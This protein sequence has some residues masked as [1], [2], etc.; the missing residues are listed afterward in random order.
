VN[1][2]AIHDHWERQQKWQQGRTGTTQK[3][4]QLQ[5][6]QRHRALSHAPRP[7]NLQGTAGRQHVHH[8]PIS[9]TLQHLR[10]GVQVAD[11][12]GPDLFQHNSPLLNR[13][14][15]WPSYADQ[16]QGMDYQDAAQHWV[17]NGWQAGMPVL[18]DRVPDAYW[19]EHTKPAVL[20]RD[21]HV[22]S[23]PPGHWRERGQ[24]RHWPW[25]RHQ[26]QNGA[27]EADEGFVGNEPGPHLMHQQMRSGT[28]GARQDDGAGLLSGQQQRSARR[29]GGLQHMPLKV[30]HAQLPSGYGAAQYW[31][32]SYGPFHSGVIS[33]SAMPMPFSARTNVHRESPDSMGLQ[34]SPAMGFPR[35]ALSRGQVKLFLLPVGYSHSAQ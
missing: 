19:E 17:Q 10:A 2:T 24:A 32:A 26:M 27:S 13:Q 14:A 28:L 7:V 30:S 11:G 6:Q 3:E 5:Q 16:Q 18:Q 25:S 12:Q 31:P 15:Q 21:H 29:Q 34:Q 1:R 33:A 9:H 4:Q 35:Q 22:A 8:R 20:D 23:E